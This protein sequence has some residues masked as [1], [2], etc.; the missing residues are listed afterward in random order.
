[1]SAGAPLA[2][3]RILEVGVMLEVPALLWQLPTLFSRVD[4]VSIGSNDLFQF[5]FAVDRGN[6]RLAR[7]YDVLSPSLL[8]LLRFI[9]EQARHHGVPL[10]LCGEMA[11][12][13]LEALALLGCGMRTLSMPLGSLGAIRLMVR[14]LEM[15]PLQDY[16][17]Y[18]S[19]LPNRSVRGH[20]RAYAA[21]HGI[22][23]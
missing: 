16:V 3:I 5:L 10:S 1:M 13:P 7:R 14:S 2:G 19:G 23:V 18:L 11:G 8:T 9:S 21:D 15:E 6:P 20:L 22:A 4:F 12:H 17:A